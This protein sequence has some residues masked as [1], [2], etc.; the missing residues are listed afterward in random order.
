MQVF[1]ERDSCRGNSGCYVTL[2]SYC[3]HPY[4]DDCVS[5]SIVMFFAGDSR[6]R[7][8]GREGVGP[9]GYGLPLPVGEWGSGAPKTPRIAHTISIPSCSQK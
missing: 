3:N 4:L 2:R 9:E 8:G 1:I 6:S 5:A 7:G